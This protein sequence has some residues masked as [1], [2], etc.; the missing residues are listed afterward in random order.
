MSMLLDA[1]KYSNIYLIVHND[2]LCYTLNACCKQ[3]LPT[4]KQFSLFLDLQMHG[5]CYSPLS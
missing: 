2:Y 1:N 3:M 5:L 4:T